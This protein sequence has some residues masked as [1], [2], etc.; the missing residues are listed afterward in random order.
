VQQV[1][2]KIGRSPVV[3]T[4]KSPL[5]RRPRWPST[6]RVGGGRHGHCGDA[7]GEARRIKLATF[8]RF[9]TQRV[10]RV[11]LGGRSRVLK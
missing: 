6:A 8:E 1:Q 3:V 11:E 7:I 9:Q 10:D 4:A 5:E 2:R